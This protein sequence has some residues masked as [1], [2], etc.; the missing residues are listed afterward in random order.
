M[1]NL[2]NLSTFLCECLWFGWFGIV[3]GARAR[4]FYFFLKTKI[5]PKGQENVR[6]HRVHAL[7]NQLGLVAL[8]CPLDWS[9]K[10]QNVLNLGESVAAA[11]DQGSRFKR[12]RLFWLITESLEL[13]PVMSDV[14]CVCSFAPC[15]YPFLDIWE[16]N[17]LSLTLIYIC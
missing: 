2:K 8:V 1:L 6:W 16:F 12:Q 10:H 5:E 7:E 14:P 3:F 15:T 11:G 17:T 13:K 4:C 9:S